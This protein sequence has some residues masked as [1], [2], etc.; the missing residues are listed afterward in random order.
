M[1]FFVTVSV[2]GTSSWFYESETDDYV[3]KDGA[4]NVNGKEYGRHK[5]RDLPNPALLWSNRA[6]N[7]GVSTSSDRGQ[8]LRPHDATFA[9]WDHNISLGA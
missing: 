2:T 6:A 9:L 7:A 1:L 5:R 4:N 8:V 3:L